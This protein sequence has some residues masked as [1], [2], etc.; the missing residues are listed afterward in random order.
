LS[1][2][3]GRAA[4]GALSVGSAVGAAL[5]NRRLLGPAEAGLLWLLA[6]FTAAGAVLGLVYPALVAYPLAILLGWIAVTIVVKAWGLSRRA[7]DLRRSADGEDA[8]HAGPPADAK[9]G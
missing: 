6:G 5:T 7:R 9:N 4:A 2:S 1:G 8:A 3:A